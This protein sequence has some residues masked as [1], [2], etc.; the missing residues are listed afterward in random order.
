MKA[1]RAVK[2]KKPDILFEPS[3]ATDIMR[4]R[5]QSAVWDYD[6][7]ITA[8][9]K[10]WGVDRLP[11]LVSDETR[12]KWWRAVDALNRAVFANE[13]D[14]VRSLVDNLIRGMNKLVEEAAAAGHK[15]QEADWFETPLKDGRV[16]RIVREWPEFA[17]RVDDKR[18]VV[19]SLQEV[20]RIVEGHS[21]VNAVKDAFPGA[22]VTEARTKQPTDTELDDEIPF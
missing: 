10:T 7:A 11:Y 19:W 15:P 9:E 20:A 21:V 1:A 4:S 14:K 16:L 3:L 5:V 13:A 18:I 8:L 6:R 2:P 17:T 22:M 12:L